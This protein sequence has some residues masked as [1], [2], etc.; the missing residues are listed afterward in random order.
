M[1]HSRASRREDPLEAHLPDP[2]VK[3]ADGS[4]PE[5][6]ALM[7][8]AVGLALL[9]VLEALGPAERLAFVLHD[10]LAVPFE[11]IAPLVGR[12]PAGARQLAS[13]AR[14]RVQGVAPV[15]DP[16]L[17]RQRQVVDAFLAA[18]RDTAAVM[19][20]ARSAVEVSAHPLCHLAEARYGHLA[21]ARRR[22][23]VLR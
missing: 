11:E 21:G 14:R 17:A 23:D 8:N 10:L 12:S 2:I 20:P 5:H 18:A 9:V 4:D 7:A 6:E 19:W 22:A 3:H 1:L 16:D 13:R 15:P